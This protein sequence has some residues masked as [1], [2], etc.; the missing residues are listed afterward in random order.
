MIVERNKSEICIS[1][2]KSKKQAINLITLFDVACVL[3][4]KRLATG[5]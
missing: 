3:S 1:F 2:I 5:K 4:E